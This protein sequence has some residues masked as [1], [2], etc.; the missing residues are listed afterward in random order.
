MDT[1]IPELQAVIAR[2]L[3]CRWTDGVPPSTHCLP[4]TRGVHVTITPAARAPAPDTVEI[5]TLLN[6]N[7]RSAD[8][9]ARSLALTKELLN[10]FLPDWQQSAE[11]IENTLRLIAA[12]GLDE[13]AV[14]T[15]V[16]GPVDLYRIFVRRN[17]YAT[18]TDIFAL[19]VI[20][21]KPSTDFWRR[22]P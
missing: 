15:S 18:R 22:D 8:A 3:D 14:T 20:T 21:R 2:L 11:W 19:I 7:P 1:P 12:V 4:V 10:L 16:R 9:E 17:E 6:A 13:T 5:M